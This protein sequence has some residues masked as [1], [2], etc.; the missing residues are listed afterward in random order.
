MTVDARELLGRYKMPHGDEV[1]LQDAI[2]EILD[3]HTVGYSRELR[4]NRADRIDFLLYDGTGLEVKVDG[5]A[6]AL[7]R[8]LHRYAQHPSVTSL[9]VVTTRARLSA[10]PGEL[11]GKRISVVSLL[12]GALL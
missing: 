1:E 8:Q 4:L 11:N 3:K 12:G 9:V 2:A 6:P 10:L 7:I 5:T